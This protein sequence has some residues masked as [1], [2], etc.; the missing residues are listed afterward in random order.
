MRVNEEKM[1]YFVFRTGLC[2]L[3]EKQNC[4]NTIYENSSCERGR[5]TMKS[6]RYEVV[7]STYKRGGLMIGWS[8]YGDMNGWILYSEMSAAFGWDGSFDTQYYH[9]KSEGLGMIRGLINSVPGT[10]AA[11]LKSFSLCR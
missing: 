4:L 8:I 10:E 11:D 9:D 6:K 2:M 5:G 7:A 3:T 1:M